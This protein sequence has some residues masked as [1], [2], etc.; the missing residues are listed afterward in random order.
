[1]KGHA[2]VIIKD[3]EGDDKDAKP[4]PT[5]TPDKPQTAPPPVTEGQA[6]PTGVLNSRAIEMPQPIYPEE[7]KTK[8]ITGTV[9]VEVTVDEEGNV[10]KAEAVEGP[11]ELRAAAVEAAKKARFGQTRL[12]GALIKVYGVLV[13][14]FQ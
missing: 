4:T 13:Y 3:V 9:K 10:I 14:K 7:A 12:H 2:S 1:V 8:H 5:P 6:P 11:K